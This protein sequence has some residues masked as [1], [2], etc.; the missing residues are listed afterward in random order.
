[1]AVVHEIQSFFA[2]MGWYVL[3]F[4]V[5]L[6]AIVFFHELGHYLVAR[7]CGVKI[8]A[9]SLGFG[10]ELFA[11]VDKRGTRWRIAAL[12]LG[13]YVKF[14][15]DAG[16]AS[17]EDD[18]AVATLSEDDRRRTLGGQPLWAR[19]LIVAAGPAANLL[20]AL[21]IF[22][23]MYISE[24]KIAHAPVI[25][26]VEP[27]SVADKAGFR[28]GD[29]IKTIDGEAIESFEQLHQMVLISTGLRLDFLILRNGAPMTLEA[30]PEL[31]LVDQGPLGKR[32]MAHLGV[33]PTKDPADVRHLY[34]GAPT[35]VIWA[36]EEIGFVAEATG[37]YVFALFAGRESVDQLSGSLEVARIA[38]EIAKISPIDLFNLA[39]LFSVSVGLM[40]LLP[41]PLLDGG[42]LMFYA[43]EALA[44]RPL[45]RRA[46]EIALRIGIAI[47]AFLVIF[48]TTHDLWRLL[49]LGN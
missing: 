43:L 31:Q 5:L 26:L 37:S 13:G 11:R 38:G 36:A 14:L 35:C 1:M 17:A 8:E 33:G 47:V 18:A 44:R 40:N 29:V 12:P 48:T 16:V 20:L 32:R 23:G 25:G 19:A 39:G 45:N 6:S 30:A 10:P 28:V 21:V 15:G 41:I 42:H 9:F 7:W 46:K 24:G 4:I 34:C 22:A 49:T 27:G 3:P 2:W